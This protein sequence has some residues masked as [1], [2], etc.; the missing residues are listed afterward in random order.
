LKARAVIVSAAAVA[1]AAVAYIVYR[2]AVQAQIGSGNYTP[3]SGQ[4]GQSIVENIRFAIEHHKRT[5]HLLIFNVFHFLWFTFAYGL[6]RI[7]KERGGRDELLV[8]SGWL[9][10]TVFIGRFFATDTDR[11]YVMAAPMV[12][13]VSAIV[14]NQ[15]RGQEQRLWIGVLAAV[16]LALNLAWVKGP[17]A[18][19]ADFAAIIIFVLVFGRVELPLAPGQRKLRT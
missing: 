17:A 9:L 13:A 5:E 14:I 12:L 10:L 11:V 6:Y 3:L 15:A 19:A 4:N 1:G 7:Y 8:I 2:L 18:L 16:Y